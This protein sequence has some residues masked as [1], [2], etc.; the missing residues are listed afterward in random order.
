MNRIAR[1]RPRPDFNEPKDCTSSAGPP[2]SSDR[3]GWAFAGVARE[4]TCN[5][6]ACIMLIR[7]QLRFEI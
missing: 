1:G 6:N 3:R 5:D 2:S 4:R 7:C